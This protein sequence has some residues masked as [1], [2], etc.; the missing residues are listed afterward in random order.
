M[1]WLSLLFM[2]G[3]YGA[4]LLLGLVIPVL[5]VGSQRSPAF[6]A[7]VVAAM[8]VLDTWFLSSFALPLG[9]ALTPFDFAFLVLAVALLARLGQLPTHDR[10]VRLWL[11]T[12]LV[13]LALFALGAVLH[14]T[15]AG[16]EYRQYFYLTVGVSYLLSFRMTPAAAQRVFATIALFALG[17]LAIAVYR[18]CMEL[19]AP[20]IHDWQES[21]GQLNWRVINAQQTFVFVA[22]LLVGLSAILSR[23]RDVPGYWWL[24]VPLLFVAVAVLQHRTDWMVLV[25]AA[26]VLVAAQRSGS[27]GRAAGALAMLAGAVV[28]VVAGSMAGGGFGESLQNSVAE[29]FK[30][31]STLNWRLDSWREVI[32]AWF[33]G[34]PAV[35]PLGFPFGHGW[36]RFIESS[37]QA[38]LLWEVSPHS[39]YVTT[40]ARGGIAGLLLV[41][42][43]MATT[44]R[45]HLAATNA[46]AG[47]AWPDAALMVALVAAQM[48]FFVSY[49]I[50]PLAT[51]LLG[52]AVS[53]AVAHETSASVHGTQPPARWPHPQVSA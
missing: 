37:G 2:S 24:L 28:I 15:R 1:S 21:P 46:P 52:V 3:L 31:K 40:L 18:W 36:R 29:P 12:G 44:V 51:L 47:A 43:V 34:G 20:G 16:V 45:R 22:L 25:A 6:G 5:V 19:F 41:L 27:G 8:H 23:R 4:A 50:V 38:G 11:F 9:L 10:L 42:A 53:A 32:R 13:W 39:F 35:W 14:K 49:S 30:Q 7:G 48:V 26:L 33:A 17:T